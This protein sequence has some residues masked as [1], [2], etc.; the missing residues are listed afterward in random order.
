LNASTAESNAISYVGWDECS[1]IADPFWDISN[2]FFEDNSKKQINAFN[3]HNINRS[4]FALRRFALGKITVFKIY[5]INYVYGDSTTVTLNRSIVKENRISHVKRWNRRY[6]I[7]K[8]C[9]S[10]FSD[11]LFFKTLSSMFNSLT[12]WLYRCK[13]HLHFDNSDYSCN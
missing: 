12:L 8:N 2:S 5:M 3:L 13:T 10:T 1:R 9:S 11:V 6:V 7:N 4:S